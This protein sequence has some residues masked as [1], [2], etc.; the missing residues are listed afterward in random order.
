MPAAVDGLA[1]DVPMI[2]DPLAKAAFCFFDT[3]NEINDPIGQH[4]VFKRR[5]AWT[6]EEHEIFLE[7]WTVM[8]HKFREIAKALSEKTAKDVIEHYYIT[9]N[10]GSLPTGKKRAKVKVKAEGAV[11]TAKE[12]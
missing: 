8:P 4:V 11:R 5:I 1:P 7:K 3:N 6:A 10:K 9:K 2:V 12:K